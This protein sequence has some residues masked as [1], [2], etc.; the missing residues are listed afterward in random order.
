MMK[1]ILATPYP[2]VDINLNGAQ[3][4]ALLIKEYIETRDL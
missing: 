2:E 3:S 1:N 4:T